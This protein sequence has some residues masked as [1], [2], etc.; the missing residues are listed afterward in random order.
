MRQARQGLQ[1]TDRARELDERAQRA[2]LLRE[3]EELQ[4]AL[5]FL[6]HDKGLAEEKAE[7]LTLELANTRRNS[8]VQSAVAVGMGMSASH[9]IVHALQHE[10]WSI[11]EDLLMPESH[12]L[13]QTLA[14]TNVALEESKIQCAKLSLIHI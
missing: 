13:V 5:E 11:R 2:I 6:R 14:E 1:S 9:R 7:L 10:D 4:A 3:K 8:S 12:S